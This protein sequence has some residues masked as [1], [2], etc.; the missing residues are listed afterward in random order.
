MNFAI[1]SLDC[2]A[3][4]AGYDGEPTTDI[5]ARWGLSFIVGIGW[6]NGK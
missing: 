2:T 3:K 1:Q 5:A 4:S 6:N